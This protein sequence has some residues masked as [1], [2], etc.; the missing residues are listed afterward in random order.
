MK[1]LL[2][3]LWFIHCIN[4]TKL[5]RDHLVDQK[6]NNLHRLSFGG[7]IMAGGMAI[8]HVTAMSGIEMIQLTGEI[9]K[10]TADALGLLPLLSKIEKTL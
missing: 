2:R 7:I 4:L 3:K 1:R 6:H 8:Y 9:V 5:L 10:V